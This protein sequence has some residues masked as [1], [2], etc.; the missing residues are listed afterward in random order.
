[1]N[2][3]LYESL[4]GLS[5]RSELLV[6]I[7]SDLDL[8]VSCGSADLLGII[9]YALYIYIPNTCLSFNCWNLL[10]LSVHLIT[11]EWRI[12]SESKCIVAQTAHTFTG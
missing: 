10:L 4:C 9:F 12:S 6:Y 7:D 3:T 8:F 11:R 2:A 5:L 1:M